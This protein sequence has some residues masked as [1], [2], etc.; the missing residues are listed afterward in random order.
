MSLDLSKDE[1]CRICHEDGSSEPLF[2]PCRCRGTMRVVHRSCLQRWRSA[3]PTPAGSYC[4][5]T[6][7]YVYRIERSLLSRLLHPLLTSPYVHVTVSA[8]VVSFL[9]VG[10]GYVFHA[11]RRVRPATF[12]S[13]LHVGI[14]CMAFMSANSVASIL[15]V[16]C[17]ILMDILLERLFHPKQ[18][19][20]FT[21]FTLYSFVKGV[22]RTYRCI[23]KR[24]LLCLQSLGD[25]VLEIEESTCST[26]TT[27]TTTATALLPSS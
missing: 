7:G 25:D 17:N 1:T 20:W 2:A 14:K 21:D 10:L 23:R 16:S 13:V 11:L 12:L 15:G 27:T 5:G 22:Y 18:L 3:A 6:C 19:V 8:A 9:T 4:C 24:C 26:T